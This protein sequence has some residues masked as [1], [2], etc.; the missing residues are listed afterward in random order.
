MITIFIDGSEYEVNEDA[1]LGHVLHEVKSARFG[2]SYRGLFCGMGICFECVVKVDDDL[3]K[4]SC[5]TKVYPGMQ[6]NTN[7]L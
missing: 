1:T 3:Y 2:S 4:R 6:V 7:S 5:M